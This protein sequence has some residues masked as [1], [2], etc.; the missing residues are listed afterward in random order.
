[1]RVFTADD[2]DDCGVISSPDPKSFAQLLVN[3]F[4]G[5]A[6]CT[7]RGGC[8]WELVGVGNW[9]IQRDMS[10]VSGHISLFTDIN[11]CDL[12]LVLRGEIPESVGFYHEKGDWNGFGFYNTSDSVV[13]GWVYL[14]VRQSSV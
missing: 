1:M 11:Q 7:D 5:K 3:L 4:G 10:D 14:F 2:P 9:E 12:L 13:F 6:S 8:F